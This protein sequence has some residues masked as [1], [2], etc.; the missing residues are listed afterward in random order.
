[1]LPPSLKYFVINIVKHK[2]KKTS[3][4]SQVLNYEMFCHSKLEK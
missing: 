3:L 1:M 2:E 4:F